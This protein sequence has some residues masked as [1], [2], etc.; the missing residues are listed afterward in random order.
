MAKQKNLYKIKA[1]V[2][3]VA[4]IREFLEGE[5]WCEVVGYQ[6]GAYIIVRSACTAEQVRDNIWNLSEYGGYLKVTEWDELED[7]EGELL[8]NPRSK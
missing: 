8:S 6:Q 1:E 5:M 2:M 3:D 4:I 7:D